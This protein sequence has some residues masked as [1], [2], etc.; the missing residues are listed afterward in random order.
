ML[1]SEQ[2]VMFHI[3]IIGPSSDRI[4]FMKLNANALSPSGGIVFSALM[5]ESGG[6]GQQT[7]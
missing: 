5:K 1:H 3:F 6:R 4:S 7:Q 2:A